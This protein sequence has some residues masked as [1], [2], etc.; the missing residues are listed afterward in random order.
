VNI[1]ALVRIH[2]TVLAILETPKNRPNIE[3]GKRRQNVIFAVIMTS[4]T[5]QLV[6]TAHYTGQTEQKDSTTE[7]F[8][9][10]AQ[11]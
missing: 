7:T 6:S 4:Q 3:M 5:F 9:F 8:V 11:D 2:Y 10:Y 1:F